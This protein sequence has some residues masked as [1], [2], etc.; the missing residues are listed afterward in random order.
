[1]MKRIINPEQVKYTYKKYIYIYIHT[2]KQVK[3]IQVVK[4]KYLLKRLKR[5]YMK[6]KKVN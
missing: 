1:M 4:T 2:Y 6:H 5:A 3:I